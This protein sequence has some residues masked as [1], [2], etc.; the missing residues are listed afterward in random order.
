MIW[1]Y[2]YP[3]I[4]AFRLKVKWKLLT[5]MPF[6]HP[7]SNRTSRVLVISATRRLWISAASYSRKSRSLC[8]V[9]IL[10]TTPNCLH[11]SLG[12]DQLLI[13]LNQSVHVSYSLESTP[14]SST[15]SKWHQRSYVFFFCSGS[16]RDVSM[17]LT[18]SLVFDQPPSV[19]I[20]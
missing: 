11:G 10:A 8:V 4:P 15:T 1:K 18:C 12:F 2:C 17:F 16:L 14:V 13:R 19:Q 5:E 9:A 3:V 6:I 7:H 20:P